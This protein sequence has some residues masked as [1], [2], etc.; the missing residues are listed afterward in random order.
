V[1]DRAAGVPGPSVWRSRIPTSPS[2]SA[3]VTF[4]FTAEPGRASFRSDA[5]I[6]SVYDKINI[7]L[8]TMRLGRCRP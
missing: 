7:Q 3:M 4:A 1:A 8:G 5:L 6:R 2:R